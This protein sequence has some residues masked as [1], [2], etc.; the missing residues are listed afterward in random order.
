MA[1]AHDD[2]RAVMDVHRPL[3]NTLWEG[4]SEV[5]QDRFLRHAARYWEIHRHRVPPVADEEIAALRAVGSL[6]IVAGHVTDVTHDPDGGF[7]VTLRGRDGEIAQRFA[8]VVNCSGP[9]RIV[10]SSP[11]IRSLIAEGLAVAGP[12]RLGVA[13]D[14]HGALLRRDGEVNGSLWTVGPPR[15][16]RLWETTA[17]PEIR[18]QAAALAQHLGSPNAPTTDSVRSL[19]CPSPSLT[20]R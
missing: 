5:D 4:L 2:W 7:T 18:D 11:L 16:G 14:R 15:R 6:T 20:T 1:Q 9:G 19:R 8:T 17:V 13:T 3:W 12:H 10:D